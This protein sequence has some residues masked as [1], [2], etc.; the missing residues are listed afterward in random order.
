[1]YASMLD[2]GASMFWFATLKPVASYMTRLMPAMMDTAV[3][4]G[5][6]FVPMTLDAGCGTPAS[7]PSC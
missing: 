7:P 3:G 2:V 5:M 1:M 4:L 6:T